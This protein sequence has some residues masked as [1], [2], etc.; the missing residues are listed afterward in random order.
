MENVMILDQNNN[1]LSIDVVRYFSNNTNKYLFYTL[2]E[3]DENDYVKLYAC[4]VNPASVAEAITDDAEWN[5]VKELIKIIIKE[6]KENNLVSINDLNLKDLSKVKVD[7][8][9]LFKLSGSVMLMLGA[10]KKE[11]FEP[12][13]VAITSLEDLLGSKTIT[14]EVAPMVEANTTNYENLYLE[15]KNENVQLLKNIDSLTKQLTDY[16]EKLNSIKEL[17]K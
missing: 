8:Y 12:K 17:L 16:Q 1:S 3:K 10:N 7:S 4:K 9:R 5:N 14:E 11:F 15:E 2:N 6:V 13:V